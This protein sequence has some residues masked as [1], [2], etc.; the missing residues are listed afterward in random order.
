MH[1]GKAHALA[2]CT[3]RIHRLTGILQ[4]KKVSA[5]PTVTPEPARL[6]LILLMA[7]S[8]QWQPPES[9]HRVTVRRGRPRAGAGVPAA[10]TDLRF[11]LDLKVCWHSE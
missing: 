10:F 6:V 2:A 5:G 8:D 7:D 3:S 9:V 4:H 1:A 11:E